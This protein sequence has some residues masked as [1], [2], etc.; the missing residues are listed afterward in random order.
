MGEKADGLLGEI[1]ENL[2]EGVAI[3]DDRGQ[4]IFANRSLAQ[5]V[6]YRQA[7][8]VNRNWMSLHAHKP[9]S[10][11]G[12]ASEG[13]GYQESALRHRNGTAVPVLINRRVLHAV[14]G[15]VLLTFTAVQES[16]D[17]QARLQQMEEMA[18][19]SQHVSSV[20]HE[21][22]NS[23]AILL[24]Q[25]KLLATKTRLISETGDGLA[26]VQ[27]QIRRMAQMVDN[28]RA[29]ADP[30][31]P[32]LET[33]DLGAVIRRTLELQKPQLQMDGI[34]VST[35]LAADL[36]PIQADPWKLQQV[37]VNLITNARQ[38]MLAQESSGR[39]YIA[40]RVYSTNGDGTARIQVRFVDTGPGIAPE[41][42]PRIFEPFFTTKEPAQ[43]MG[44]GLSI[45][46]QIVRRH[47]GTIWAENNPE[48]GAVFVLE[49]PV[50]TRS[51]EETVTQVRTLAGHYWGI[52]RHAEGPSTRACPG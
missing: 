36:P 37:F 42:M 19:T 45:C 20:V 4:V 10:M 51:R 38:A 43:G 34:Q 22:K 12:E 11:A 28:L 5:L 8:L 14:Q 50:A 31:E 16:Q 26:V 49:L 29:C 46:D 18:R 40:A 47:Q 39:L 17:H 30:L 48:G 35:E 13:A 2:A 44:L 1:L 23:L 52:L 24:L 7:E 6:G 9:Q 15:A 27:D 32:N 21:M 3:V 25:T 33:V 41:L